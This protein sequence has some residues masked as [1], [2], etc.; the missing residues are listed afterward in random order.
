M[1]KIENKKQIYKIK[2]KTNIES[3]RGKINEMFDESNNLFKGNFIGTLKGDTF[4][5]HTNFSININVKG[6]ITKD[7]D[8]TII[9]L[10]INDCSPDYKST[11]SAFFLVFL[12]IA[13]IIIASNKVTDIIIYLIPIVIFGLGYLVLRI[14]MYIFRSF[15]KPKLKRIADNF[16][17]DVNGEIINIG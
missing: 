5:G 15:F 7:K 14:K 10:T 6:R 13:L 11:F 9:D 16:T 8:N 1:N 2:V 4:S 17:K 3:V 12:F